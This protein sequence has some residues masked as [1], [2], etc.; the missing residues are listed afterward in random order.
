M[1]N[2]KADYFLDELTDWATAIAFYK[3]EVEAFVTRLEAVISRNSIPHIAE[4]VAYFRTALERAADAFY[5]IQIEMEQQ[6]TMLAG[7]HTPV[8]NEQISDEM[9]KRQL[10]LRHNMLAAEQ[11]Y[12]DT[13]FECYDFL[14]GVLKK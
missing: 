12:L 1:S 6:E 2:I 7:D 14:A 13:K 9:E 3:R 10:L 8:Q 4:K 11:A 5:R